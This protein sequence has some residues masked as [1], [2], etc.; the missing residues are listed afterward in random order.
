[1]VIATETMMDN[2]SF[3]NTSFTSLCLYLKNCPMAIS[4]QSIMAIGI[5]Q[6]LKCSFTSTGGASFNPNNLLITG[7][8]VVKVTCTAE[9][10]ST[11]IPIN[12]QNSREVMLSSEFSLGNFFQLITNS[13][14]ESTTKNIM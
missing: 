10:Q 7:M 6:E 9:I 5:C 2:I 11:S 4:K 3:L 14:I 12:I 13:T 1:M 8:L